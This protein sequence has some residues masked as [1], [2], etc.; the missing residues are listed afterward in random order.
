M[1]GEYLRGSLAMDFANSKAYVGG[2][3]QTAKVNEYQYGAMGT[4]SDSSTWPLLAISQVIEPWWDA[5]VHGGPYGLAMQNGQLICCPR[6]FYDMT[7]PA[8]LTLFSRNGMQQSVNV[9][10]QQFAGFVK[11]HGS[12]E[13]GGGGYESGQGTS[14]GPTLATLAGNKLIGSY[15]GTWE[16]RCPR[17]ANYW[18]HDGKDSWVC[19]APRN[20]EGRWACDRIWGGGIRH[21]SGI[22]YW[23]WMGT[24]DLNYARQNECFAASGFDKCYRYRFDPVTYALLGWKEETSMGKVQGQDISPDGKR[25]YMVEGAYWVM[26]NGTPVYRHQSVLKVYEILSEGAR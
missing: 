5:N 1:A 2:F 20:G 15:G 24:G 6:V 14:L 23:A 22:Y 4:G 8:T 25:L 13:L 17:P 19:L 9:P 11:G 16:G 12:L 21:T 10:R 18:P 7:P 26:V 3:A